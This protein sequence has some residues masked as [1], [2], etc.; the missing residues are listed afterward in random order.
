MAISG[1]GGRRNELHEQA[2]RPRSRV[3]GSYGHPVHPMLVTLPIGAWVGSLA[4]DVIS[5]ASDEPA[6]FAIGSTWL[7]GIGLVCAVIAG[8]FGL[9]DF[10]NVPGDTPAFR[11]GLAHLSLNLAVVVL[12]AVQLVVR[13]M[14]PDAGPVPLP[15]VGLAV[16]SLVALGASGWLGGR[17]T[18]RY[19]VRVAG[20]ET[21]ALGFL[22]PRR[23]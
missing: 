1:D 12:Y 22:R 3:A 21:Q 17:L 18:Y 4:F 23:R 13:G 10:L 16:F 9:L 2:K 19:G 20:E 8:G 14:R 11:T 7:V 15:L 5:H 6:V